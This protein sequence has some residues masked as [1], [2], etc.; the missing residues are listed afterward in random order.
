MITAKVDLDHVQ[1]GLEAMISAGRSVRPVLASMRIPAR[2]DQMEHGRAQSGP[3]GRWPARKKVP[4]KRARRR[5]LLGRL[6][7][8]TVTRV[9]A[10]GLVLE[11]KVKWSAI[12]Q[13]GGQAGNGARIPQRTFLWWSKEILDEVAKRLTEHVGGSW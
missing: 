3:E 13:E 5:R 4:G 8:A 6:S 2:K 12:H 1:R 7:S 11:S 10:K 9:T